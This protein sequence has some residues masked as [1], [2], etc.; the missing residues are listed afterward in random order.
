[1]TLTFWRAW[2]LPTWDVGEIGSYFE[3]E[4]SPQVAHSYQ[5][6]V[7]ESRSSNC[8]SCVNALIHITNIRDRLDQIVSIFSTW[9]LLTTNC[10]QNAM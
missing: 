3:W 4:E 1:M 8:Q 10:A 9:Y 2:P 7:L 5:I 6:E